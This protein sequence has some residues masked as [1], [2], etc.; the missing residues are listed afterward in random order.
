MGNRQW[1]EILFTPVVCRRWVTSSTSDVE[2]L[3]TR[4]SL[5][6]FFGLCV[7]VVYDRRQPVR[8]HS[9]QGRLGRLGVMPSYI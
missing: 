4:N 7:I 2:H 5:S 8:G 1:V 3:L 9:R 6:L